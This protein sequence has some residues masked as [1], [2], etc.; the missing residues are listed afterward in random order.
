M[1]VKYVALDVTNV[2][3]L[4]SQK[5]SKKIVKVNSSKFY[6]IQMCL[7]LMASSLLACLGKRQCLDFPLAFY[8]F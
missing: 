4:N 5:I 6:L 8:S 3:A 7:K 1:C 2:F